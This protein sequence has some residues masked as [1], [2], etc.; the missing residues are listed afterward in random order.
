M[1]LLA[2]AEAEEVEAVHGVPGQPGYSEKPC[3]DKTQKKKDGRKE[4]GR[5]GREEERNKGRKGLLMGV[6]YL[7]SVCAPRSRGWI[8]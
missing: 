8:V 3:L 5:E 7:H 4:E 2:V 6:F 1:H